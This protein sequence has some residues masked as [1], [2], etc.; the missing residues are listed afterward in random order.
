MEVLV[1][2]EPAL[3]VCVDGKAGRFSSFSD[4]ADHKRKP[5]D[6]TEI[7]RPRH[8]TAPLRM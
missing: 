2:N 8:S 4:L 7:V 1:T 6:C 5:R 3:Q